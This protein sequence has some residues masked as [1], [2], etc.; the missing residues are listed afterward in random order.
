M[1]IEQEQVNSWDLLSIWIAVELL[2]CKIGF[3]ISYLVQITKFHTPSHSRYIQNG[4][5]LFSHGYFLNCP[6]PLFCTNVNRSPATFRNYEKKEETKL[7]KIKISGAIW[8][9]TIKI[10]YFKINKK[11]IRES[12]LFYLVPHFVSLLIAKMGH[13]TKKRRNHLTSSTS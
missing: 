7:G 10:E 11:N 3:T 13:C 1:S 4:A 2:N 6:Y 12:L 9:K 5:K 8:V